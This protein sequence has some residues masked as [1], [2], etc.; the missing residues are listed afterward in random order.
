M[1]Y[2]TLAN[3]Y[4]TKC[5]QKASAFPAIECLKPTIN[6]KPNPTPFPTAPSQVNLCTKFDT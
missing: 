5:L 3:G 1:L 6:G 2:K 4:S